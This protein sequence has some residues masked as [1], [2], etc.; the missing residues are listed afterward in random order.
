MDKVEKCMSPKKTR[1]SGIRRGNKVR[2]S[3]TSPAI[4]HASRPHPSSKMA[5]SSIMA[6]VTA[7]ILLMPI[8]SASS[9]R[10]V[11]S[12][13]FV[14][15]GAARSAIVAPARM[16]PASRMSG[17]HAIGH[18][19]YKRTPVSSPRCAFNLLPILRNRRTILHSSSSEEQPTGIDG[20]PPMNE[21]SD[22]SIKEEEDAQETKSSR[23]S[24]GLGKNQPL[25]PTY[26]SNTDNS[27][28]EEFSAALNWNAPEP[29]SKPSIPN[30]QSNENS[31]RIKYD[32]GMGKNAPLNSNNSLS[33]LASAVGKK[34]NSGEDNSST[35]SDGPRDDRRRTTRHLLTMG[36]EESA[37]LTKAVWDKGHFDKDDGRGVSANERNNSREGLDPIPTTTDF[38]KSEPAN[39]STSG[40]GSVEPIPIEVAGNNVNTQQQSIE[41]I[42]Y[43]EIDLSVPLSVY[44]MGALYS[45]NTTTPDSQPVDL[46][47]DLMRHE[48]QIEAVREPLLVSFLYSTILNHPTLESALAFHLANRLSSPAMLSTQ[49]MSLIREALDAD[50]EF[51]RNLR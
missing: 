42:D 22:A 26:N 23:Y 2:T 50:P 45:N 48:A 15:P 36:D 31:Q 43:K 19:S 16:M 37:R 11:D 41:I 12:L 39:M 6:F 28:A 29:V 1:Y 40:K 14:A 25:V 9:N 27:P 10:A 32:M 46:V 35:G 34:A 3:Q 51:R 17:R 8:A 24:L 38:A 4:R 21:D 20:E 7:M 5:T 49:I 18:D 47:W 30:E 33:N 13:A 44:S